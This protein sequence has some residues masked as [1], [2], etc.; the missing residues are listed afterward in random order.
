MT[1]FMAPCWNCE[2]VPERVLPAHFIASVLVVGLRC[3]SGPWCR[4]LCLGGTCTRPRG[5]LAPRGKLG[6][7]ALRLV[8]AEDDLLA[9]EGLRPVCRTKSASRWPPRTGDLPVCWRR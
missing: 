2:G 7:V 5:V 9:R 1:C 6:Q 4:N 8:I 3:G